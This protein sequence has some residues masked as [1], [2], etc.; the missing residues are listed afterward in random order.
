[1]ADMNMTG[2]VEGTLVN[3]GDSALIECD[4]VEVVL[5]SVRN[6]A[7]G[8]NMFTNLG[9]DLTKKQIV[10][11]KSSQHF[12]A[13]FSKIAS[14]VLYCAAP[15]VVTKDLN[16]LTFKKITHPRWPITPPQI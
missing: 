14:R 2:M 12:Y 6:Q 5:F 10:V 11:V 1:M 15:G 7:F 8:T 9:C 16:T 4:G 13:H 3:C